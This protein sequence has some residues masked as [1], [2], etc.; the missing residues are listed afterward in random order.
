M[1]QQDV[2]EYDVS[3]AAYTEAFEWR[4]E[5]A[6]AVVRLQQMTVA[7]LV[8][9]DPEKARIYDTHGFAGLV[10]SEGYAETDVFEVRAAAS[11]RR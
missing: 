10:R 9:K 8:L 7:F 11:P 3:E 6:A 2:R 1:F 5:H 4:A